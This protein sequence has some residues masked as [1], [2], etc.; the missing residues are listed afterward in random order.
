MAE[1]IKPMSSH[2]SICC[3]VSSQKDLQSNCHCT[4][5]CEHIAHKKPNCALASEHNFLPPP[6]SVAVPG[7]HEEGAAHDPAVAQENV[8]VRKSRLPHFQLHGLAR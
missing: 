7:N 1:A 8:I 3:S 6:P 5:R 4:R 2:C